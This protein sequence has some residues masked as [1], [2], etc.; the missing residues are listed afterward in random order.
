MKI[1]LGKYRHY[2]GKFYEVIGEAVHSETS[3]EMVIYRALYEDIAFGK[4]AVFVRPK[5][6][7]LKKVEIKGEK[8]PRLNLFNS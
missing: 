2:K 3:E 8:I 5:G 4:N 6:I 7:F 1:K